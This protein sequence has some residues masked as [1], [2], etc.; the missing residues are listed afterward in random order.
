MLKPRPRLRLI[1]QVDFHAT[2]LFYNDHTKVDSSTKARPADETLET[3]T[4]TTTKATTTTK[5]SKRASAAT[6]HIT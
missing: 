5:N 1:T 2:H 6:N 3:T 4:K